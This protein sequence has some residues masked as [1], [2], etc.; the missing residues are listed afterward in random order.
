[1]LGNE[2]Q[3]RQVVRNLVDNAVKYTPASGQI[4][5]TCE[6]RADDQAG[7]GDT[8]APT[9]D[10]GPLQGRKWAVMKITDQGIGIAAQ[11]LPHLFERFFRVNSE[12]AVPGTG[13]GLPIVREFVSL[14]DGWITV[15]STPG[16]G[17]T[18]T[19]YLPLADD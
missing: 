17:S 19:V 5:C 9:F 18:F 6:T 2:P 1:M 14:H 7:A 8:P 10:A 16:E 15:A 12:G 13:L 4:A 11:D 3:L